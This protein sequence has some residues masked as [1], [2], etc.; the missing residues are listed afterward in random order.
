MSP[1]YRLK[2]TKSRSFENVNTNVFNLKFKYRKL[3]GGG[4]K[5]HGT[6]NL[7]ETKHD[8][9]L[10]TGLT[11][12]H[13]K[14]SRPVCYKNLKIKS[15]NNDLI[16]SNGWS[17]EC[18][19]KTINYLSNYVV[20]RNFEK[21]PDILADNNHLDIDFLVDNCQEFAFL[22]NAVKVVNKKYRTQYYVLIDNIKVFI[23]IRYI[24]DNY[25]SRYWQ[26]DILKNRVYDHSRMVYTP[27]ANDHYYMLLYHA[28][29]HKKV[30]SQDYFERLK[31]KNN[32][33]FLM[34]H[35]LLVFLNNKNYRITEPIDL[36][37]YFSGNSSF[38]RKF[39]YKIYPI[40]LKFKKL[41]LLSLSYGFFI[42][43]KLLDIIYFPFYF[44]YFY[45]KYK[46]KIYKFFSWKNRTKLFVGKY[47]NKLCFIKSLNFKFIQ[48]EAFCL[49]SISNFDNSLVPEVY[50]T[51]K[52]TIFPHIILEYLEDSIPFCPNYYNL[53]ND[54]SLDNLSSKILN[55]FTR[56]NILHGDLTNQNIL[57]DK[58]SKA[59]YI[60]DFAFAKGISLN[61]PKGLRGYLINYSMGR[62]IRD[63][64]GN[65]CDKTALTKLFRL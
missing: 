56:L 23:D 55:I 64:G 16:G 28:L 38:Y 14:N 51:S 48:N 24:N 21:F 50:Y 13:Y 12:K 57:I 53:Y 46:A 62:E 45:I 3:T 10:L 37:V 47:N 60:I 63:S 43:D 20:M 22:T 4:H 9:Y 39:F 61:K 33:F 26:K 8:L 2:D 35:K 27:N 49:N 7:E 30:I 42:F 25:Y 1:F 41:I 58:K 5:I 44:F 18:F 65:I 15:L 40:K 52:N 11:L 6:N 34:K 54:E 19:F 59:V 29:I 36:S 17:N 32:S 31:F